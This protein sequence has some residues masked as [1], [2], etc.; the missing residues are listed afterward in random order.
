MGILKKMVSGGGRILGIIKLIIKYD[1]SI[2]S[3]TALRVR[4]VM[5]TEESDNNLIIIL[6]DQILSSELSDVLEDF[7]SIAV[8]NNNIEEL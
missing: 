6:E 8:D 4:I 2:I 1:I 7:E 3:S 5:I